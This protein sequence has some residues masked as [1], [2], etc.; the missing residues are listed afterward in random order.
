MQS[1]FLIHLIQMVNKYSLSYILASLAVFCIALQTFC[2][3]LRTFLIKN[4]KEAIRKGDL[5]DL[6]QSAF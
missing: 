4:M 5:W 6:Y 3:A 2:I 1:T